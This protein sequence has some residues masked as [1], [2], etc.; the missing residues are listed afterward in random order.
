MKEMSQLEGEEGDTT[1][2]AGD[3]DL[4]QSDIVHCGTAGIRILILDWMIL[5]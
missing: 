1:T 2:H 5:A 4:G 3:P